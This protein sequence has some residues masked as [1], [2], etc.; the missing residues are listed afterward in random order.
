MAIPL[1]LP[2]TLFEDRINQ[3]DLRGLK[4]FRIRG[5]RVEGTIDLFN[6]FNTAAVLNEITVVGSAFR[7]PTQILQ[8]RMVKFGAK[9]IF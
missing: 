9:F 6:V 1:G 2:W 3:L 5:A 7:Q 8:G 4:A